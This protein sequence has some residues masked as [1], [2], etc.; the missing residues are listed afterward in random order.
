MP[1]LGEMDPQSIELPAAQVLEAEVL[2]DAASRADEVRCVVESFS[3]DH[4]WGPLQWVPVVDAAGVFYPKKGDRALV[5]A[6]DP[7]DGPPAIAVWFPS[8]TAPDKSF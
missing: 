2:D 8:A 6:P 3:P 5:I 7:E 1:R 4:F